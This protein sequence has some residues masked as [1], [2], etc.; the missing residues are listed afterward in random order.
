MLLSTQATKQLAFSLYVKVY[1]K[2]T[3]EVQVY[4]HFLCITTE[5]VYCDQGHTEHQSLEYKKR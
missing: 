3:F 4:F 2:C 5:I 1:Q